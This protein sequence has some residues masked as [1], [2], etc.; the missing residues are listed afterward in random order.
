MYYV[1]VWL[2]ATYLKQDKLSL[3]VACPYDIA[4]H[5]ARWLETFGN[6]VR[7]PA[8]LVTLADGRHHWHMTDGWQ[9]H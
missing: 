9:Q 1:A 6:V 2:S 5:I 8:T 3:L 7:R 4:R